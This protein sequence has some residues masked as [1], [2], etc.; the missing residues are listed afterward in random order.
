MEL[1]KNHK[2]LEFMH[3]L[4]S[5]MP[6]DL[7][8][9]AICHRYVPLEQMS[10]PLVREN[11]TLE[12]QKNCPQLPTNSANNE[13]NNQL[14]PYDTAQQGLWSTVNITIDPR[15][16]GSGRLALDSDTDSE[17]NTYNAYDRPYSYSSKSEEA[18]S[19]PEGV[20]KMIQVG[21]CPR[22]HVSVQCLQLADN[23]IQVDVSR[24]MKGK[25]GKKEDYKTEKERQDQ[26]LAGYQTEKE[27]ESEDSTAE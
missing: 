5:Y 18:G 20:A 19:K 17:K 11:A 6:D 21:I 27:P 24:R 23:K 4:Q 2:W 25:K 13:D 9:C 10:H 22:H 15:G 14:N 7:R 3:Q 12:G 16:S 1:R 8:Y 26:V